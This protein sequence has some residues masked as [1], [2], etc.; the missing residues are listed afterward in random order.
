MADVY[1][2]QGGRGEWGLSWSSF[3]LSISTSVRMILIYLSTVCV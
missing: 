3:G 2:Y 1:N